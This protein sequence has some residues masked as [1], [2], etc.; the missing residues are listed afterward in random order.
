MISSTVFSFLDLKTSMLG[1]NMHLISTSWSLILISI[2]LGLHLVVYFNNLRKKIKQS[3]FEY[4]IYFVILLLFIYGIYAFFKTEPWQELFLLTYFK[5][6]D[7]EQLP[8]FFYLEKV[9]I[10]FSVILLTYGSIK[11]LTKRK[12]VK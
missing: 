1:R 10:V 8:I 5:F 12:A 7:Y 2:H 11:L 9:G 6:F 3:T 4:T